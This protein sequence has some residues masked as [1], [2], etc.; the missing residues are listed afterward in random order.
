MTQLRD[1]VPGRAVQLG[2]VDGETGVV[3]QSFQIAT[4]VVAVPA[5]RLRFQ[6]ALSPAGDVLQVSVNVPGV[7]PG[8][9]AL[10]RNSH[11][12]R[13]TGRD[14]VVDRREPGF[15]VHHML[16]DIRGIDAGEADR[17]HAKDFRVLVGGY[18]AKFAATGAV[19]EGLGD[20]GVALAGNDPELKG[21]SGGGN[22][23][24]VYIPGSAWRGQVTPVR[25]LPRTSL[26]RVV[27]HTEPIMHVV[28]L[29]PFDPNV[30]QA[31]IAALQGGAID[32]AW[33]AWFDD[34]M[35]DADY[36]MRRG[37][38]RGANRVTLGLAKAL[39]ASHP[40][41]INDPFGLTFWEAQVDRQM[42][43]L[44]RPPARAFQEYGIEQ[45]AVRA[46]PVRLDYQMGMMGG[47]W[48]PARL[49]DQAQALLDE[50]LER[51]VKRL[52]AAECDPYPVVGLTYEAVAYARSRDLGLY[53]AL[54]VVGPNGEGLPGANVVMPDRKRID[55][56][57]RARIDAASQP[58]KKPGLLSRLFGRGT[59]PVSSNGRHPE[60]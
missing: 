59:P 32:T 8:Y 12:Q 57:I 3:E 44:M 38:E 55:P 58:E 18:P 31:Y 39:A 4:G 1:I 60:G 14:G 43:M 20:I 35:Q 9:W 26:P 22:A 48:I 36:Q 21:G 49:M 27:T 33:A 23:H 6:E 28:S 37:S 24:L 42:G 54:D 15:L 13:R 25:I 17:A 40:V 19:D 52:V 56:A 29:H 34:G 46:M 10:E 30:V 5:F 7:E 47:A 50:H 51:S 41:F 11:D 53:E 45:A 2:T 16:Q